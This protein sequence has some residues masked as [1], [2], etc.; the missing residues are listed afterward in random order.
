MQV[1]AAA[2]GSAPM[3]DS[4]LVAAAPTMPIAPAPAKIAAPGKKA[5]KAERVSAKASAPRPT[6]ASAPT[7]AAE[8]T[9]AKMDVSPATVLSQPKMQPAL[10]ESEDYPEAQPENES[11]DPA[12]HIYFSAYG[13]SP[14]QFKWLA[15]N[16]K[17]EYPSLCPA[18]SVA[19]VD[20]V[21]LFTHD[22]DTYTGAMP[23]PVH[24]DRSGFSDFNPLTTVD[25]ALLS[26]ADAD[27]AHREY[28]W[29]FRMR[30]GA[31][32]PAK[33][34]PRRRPQFTT[35]ESKGSARALE[36]AFGYVQEQGAT[37]IAANQ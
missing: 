20:F 14:S 31:F 8:L 5:A 9:E 30:R 28:I 35:V 6:P 16:R 25:T 19:S 32:D 27:K 13:L 26:G 22:S 1:R 15:A 7:A 29:V 18:P 34:S 37:Q 4:T 24:T 3:P 12:C 17:K 11:A 23:E 36:D 2:V 10:V 33:F 21:I